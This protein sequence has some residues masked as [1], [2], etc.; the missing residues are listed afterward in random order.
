LGFTFARDVPKGAGAVRELVA[1]GAL[2]TPLRVL[3][4]G[5]GLGAM[6]WG[7]VRALE[8]AGERGSIDATW[9]DEDAQALELGAAIVRLRAPRGRIG[10]GMD[11]SVRR[12]T[13]PIAAAGDLGR[14]DLVLFGHV[15][16]E[17]DVLAPDAARIERHVRLLR[18]ALEEWTEDNGSVVVVEPALRDRTRHLHRVRDGLIALGAT[19]FAPCLH[20][21]PCPALARDTDWC[22][23][24]LPVDLPAWL[25][26]VALA[27]GLRRQGLSFSYLVVRRDGLHLTK[28][29]TV[30]PGAV[31]LRMVSDAMPS[32]GKREIFLCGEF[33][34]GPGRAR[35]VRLDRDAS[36]TNAAWTE[37]ERGEVAVVS[38]AP[39]RERPR[40]AAASA[41]GVA[42][43]ADGSESR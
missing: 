4:V 19:I 11:W 33:S 18:V 30:V 36:A 14:F 25:A 15:L 27:A 32:K 9:L 29:L 23:E 37:L 12:V 1:T 16:S 22:H 21:A 39:K 10:S 2:R 41:V 28:R 40:I 17:L 42:V 13:R 38:P 6:T 20:E 5:A 3:D 35:V 24:A 7:V 43:G 34:E 26:P 31:H 8:A